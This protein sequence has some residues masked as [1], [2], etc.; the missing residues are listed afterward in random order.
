MDKSVETGSWIEEIIGTFKPDD[1]IKV[2]G[3]PEEMTSKACWEAFWVSTVAGI[4]PGPL[5]MA[6]IVPELITITKIQINLVYRIAKFHGK[7]QLVTPTIILHILATALGIVLG[8]NLLRKIGTRFIVKALSAQVIKTLAQ[9]LGVKIATRLLAKIG[10]RWIPI[11]T[12]PIFGAF[13]KSQTTR[14]GRESNKVF[15]GDIE[16]EKV[17]KCSQ[18]HEVPEESKFCPECGEKMKTTETNQ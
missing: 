3:T 12:A 13:S 9:K 2:T 6:T 1:S 11:V 15:S 14:V 17:I 8:R 10:A 18:G 16:F 4:P 5:G 7:E